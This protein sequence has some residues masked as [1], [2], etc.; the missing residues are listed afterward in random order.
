[1]GKS[2]SPNTQLDVHVKNPRPHMASSVGVSQPFCILGGGGKK[3]YLKH[4][5]DQNGGGRK[6]WRS[7]R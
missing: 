3:G 5:N 6:R 1:M 4:D 2:Q 7:I